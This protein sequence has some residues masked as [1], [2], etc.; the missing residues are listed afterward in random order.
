MVMGTLVWPLVWQTESSP[1]DRVGLDIV[2]GTVCPS[3][4]ETSTGTITNG[5]SIA[6]NEDV[7]YL[8]LADRLEL[9]FIVA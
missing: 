5:I 6:A 8:I 2:K 3:T 7:F 9:F 1:G 4:E